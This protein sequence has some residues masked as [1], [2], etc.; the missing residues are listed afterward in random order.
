MK[1]KTSPIIIGTRGSQL[2]L[3]QANFTKEI[4]E[5]NGLSVEIKII[6]TKGD[7]TQEWNLSFDKIEG[8]G[9]FTKE[10]EEALL[11][12]EIDLAVHSCK[13]LPTENPAGLCIAAYSARANP[14]D[15]LIIRKDAVDAT[16][17]LKLKEGALVGT[18]S[19][20]R[21]AQ[22]LSYR[23]DIRLN[24]MRGN[25][26]TRVNKL[27]EL[28]YDAIVLA[29]AGLE[30]LSIDLSEFE[31]IEL[32]APMFI[33]A[34]AQGV[35]AFQI[36]A[37]DDELGA[38]CNLL[39]DQVSH[40]ITAIERKILH[41]FEGG[42]QIPLGVF[43]NIKNN[44]LH[45]WISYADSWDAMPKRTHFVL[46]AEE[47]EK[48][49]DTKKLLKL[50]KIKKSK[51]VFISSD[52]QEDD[53]LV[54][55]LKVHGYEL[56]YQSLLEF[57]PLEFSF[58]QHPDWLFFSSKN[59]VH[60]FFSQLPKDRDWSGIKFAAINQS[61]AQK[62]KEL[63]LQVDFI[64]SGGDMQK[65]ASDFDA[66]ASGL[67]LFPQASHSAQSVQK[68]LSQEK[69]TQSLIVYQN[70][71]KIDLP[72]NIEDILI[73][74]SPMNVEVYLSAHK[75]L[76]NQSIIAIGESTASRISALQSHQFKVA[77]DPLPW[78]VLD[79]VFSIE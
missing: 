52:L 27:R 8:K 38:I 54:R 31:I 25:V 64:G 44:E 1:G 35:L 9:F 13:D 16:K 19:A 70:S 21:K 63:G 30:R 75:I 57:S 74:T 6:K 41:D 58:T 10:L 73:F 50:L 42:C 33:P 11:V 43:S 29:A 4:L 60:F 47:D 59:G 20:R 24:D 48:S 36:R 68:Q 12:K 14:F 17:V 53:F 3:W 66:L 49:L 61:T 5:R 67:I 28:Q 56:K 72:V 45:T 46:S 22:L 51:S 79:V 71:P 65:V 76:E 15:V 2:A 23:P 69:Q 26:P 40:R 55:A 78:S 39:D 62:L 77:F 18:S 37:D 34:P 32:S 7:A